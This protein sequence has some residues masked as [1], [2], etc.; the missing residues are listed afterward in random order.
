M[1]VFPAGLLTVLTITTQS[2][3][4]SQRLPKVS[5]VK[6]IDVWM[7]MGLVFVFGAIIEYAIVNVLD[8]K[9]S[10]QQEKKQQLEKV[11]YRLCFLNIIHIGELPP[12][13]HLTIQFNICAKMDQ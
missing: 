7:S 11:S 9:Y 10:N 8:R 1:N 5:Y 4:I 12:L 6:A 2:T 3:G 13:L